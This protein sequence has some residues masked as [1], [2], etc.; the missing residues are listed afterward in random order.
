MDVSLWLDEHH[1]RQLGRCFLIVGIPVIVAMQILGP[2]RLPKGKLP[3]GFRAPMLAIELPKSSQEVETILQ[4]SGGARRMKN[5]LLLDFGVILL[6]ASVLAVLGAL[7]YQSPVPVAGRIA[8]AAAALLGITA[9][10]LD[11]VENIRIWKVLDGA[12]DPA[13][14]HTLTQV[15]LWKWGLLAVAFLLLAGL[16]LVDAP[17]ARVLAGLC[18]VTGVVGLIGLKDNPRL[19][20]VTVLIAVTLLVTLI[21][22]A[23]WP[24]SL[25][26]TR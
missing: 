14:L 1:L 26:P 25:R 17:M 6:Y 15:S 18:L 20:W 4:V 16:F 3:R 2:S 7:L 8:G 9:G 10:L 11:V 22:F 19:E 5:G 21:V 12:R 13:T 23:F 24:E